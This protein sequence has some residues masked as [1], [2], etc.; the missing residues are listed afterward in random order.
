MTPTE[1]LALADLT[2]PNAYEPE[3]KLRWLS[4]L[5]GRIRAELFD[6]FEDGDVPLPAGSD[7][8]P[9]AALQ[10]PRPW[11]ELYVPYL[12][13]RIDLENGEL[14]R[15]NND[16]AYFNRLY[17]S[18]ACWYAHNHRAKGVDRLRF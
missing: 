18:F 11:D 6:A 4:D 12:L 3:L 9:E 13:L 17:R 16:A 8:D 7:L 10:V 15:Y 14:E 2:R 5:E 1:A